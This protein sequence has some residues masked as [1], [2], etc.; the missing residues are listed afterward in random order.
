MRKVI[1]LGRWQDAADMAA[2]ALFLAS[3]LARNICGQT[4]NVDG[5]FVMHW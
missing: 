3:P 5:G 1:P 2:M 4:L